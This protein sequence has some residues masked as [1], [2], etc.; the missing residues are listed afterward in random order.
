M[1]L[2]DWFSPTFLLVGQFVLIGFVK[3]VNFVFFWFENTVKTFH[4]DEWKYNPTVSVGASA[5]AP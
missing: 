1:F 2:I 3:I 5:S 4:H